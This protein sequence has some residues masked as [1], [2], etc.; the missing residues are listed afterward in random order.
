MYIIIAGAGAIGTNLIEIALK[1][2]Q[3]VAVIE[4]DPHRAEEISRNYDVLVVQADAA[5]A[6]ALKEA[7]AE[8][9]DA[10]IATTRDDATNLMVIFLGKEL[11][12]PSLVSVVNNKQHISLFRQLGANVMENPEEIVAEYLYNAVRRPKI[13]DLITLSGGAQVFKATITERSPLV[14]KSLRESGRAGL[15]PQ[16]TLIVA[17]ERDDRLIIP[18]GETVIEAGDLITVF[19]G[20]R[21]NDE[22]VK[23]FTG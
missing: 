17:I 21:A 1:D 4:R 20:E 23:R 18:F 3:N 15:I 14:G 6:E 5:T 12:V 13:K 8:R 19:S 16:Y 11:G 10:L 22:L 7:R 9:A 2:R